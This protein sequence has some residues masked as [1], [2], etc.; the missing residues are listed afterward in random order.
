MSAWGAR[1]TE[2]ISIVWT[3]GKGLALGALEGGVELQLWLLREKEERLTVAWD[4]PKAHFLGK[5][6]PPAEF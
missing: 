4:S 3:V 5:A 1:N 6:L 2:R